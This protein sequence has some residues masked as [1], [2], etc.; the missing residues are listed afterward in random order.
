MQV[1]HSLFCALINHIPISWR[2]HILFFQGFGDCMDETF[3]FCTS[4]KLRSNV[5]EWI[6]AGTLGSIPSRSNISILLVKVLAK[7]SSFSILEPVTG[8]SLWEKTHELT[9]S[10]SPIFTFCDRPF[11][12]CLC[13]PRVSVYRLASFLTLLNK[14]HHGIFCLNVLDSVFRDS[15]PSLSRVILLRSFS[16]Y[17]WSVV[18]VLQSSLFTRLGLHKLPC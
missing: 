8:P 6:T 12:V 4:T 13:L 14:Q 3:G 1:I 5:V 15:R 9:S 18:F 10:S 2:N 16:N 11:S 7:I 17:G